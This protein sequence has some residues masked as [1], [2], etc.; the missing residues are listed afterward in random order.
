MREIK[1]KTNIT[2]REDGLQQYFNDIKKY[3]PLSIEEETRI[4][5]QIKHAPTQAERDSAL[6]T[7]VN[8]NLR[9]VVSVAKQYQNDK[10]TLMDIIQEGNLGLIVAGQKFDETKGFKFISYAV[11]W[12][13]QQIMMAIGET[14]KTIRLPQNKVMAVR[15]IKEVQ[16]TFYAT[17]GYYPSNFEVA[18]I[19][20]EREDVVEELIRNDID[21]NVGSTD[22]K[23]D[24]D[25]D[26]ASVIDL[27]SGSDITDD[28]LMNESKLRQIQIVLKQLCERDR[29]IVILTYGLDGNGERSKEE[30]A[31]MFNLSRE[32]VR[33]IA[34]FAIR[35]LRK[36]SAS[37]KTYI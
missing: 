6:R 10:M 3:A 27:I 14:S 20:G 19:I 28:K 15:K 25:S 29:Q 9:F 8:A 23:V 22:M 31:K 5:Y 35:K 4:A 21:S 34:D 18:K 16:N 13:R 12:I 33:Q 7:L 32:R 37:L 11:W 26:S 36:N 17:N 30:I 1:I 2:N 24:D